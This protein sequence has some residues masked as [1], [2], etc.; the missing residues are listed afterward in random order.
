MIVTYVYVSGAN[1]DPV[2][3]ARGVHVPGGGAHRGQA[4]VGV[5]VRGRLHP[6]RPA[7][8]CAL[9]QVGVLSAVYGYVCY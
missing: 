2:R 7:G 1:S 8:L 9:R 3:G 4:A 5:P 6:R